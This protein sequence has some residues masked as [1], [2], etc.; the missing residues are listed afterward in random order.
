MATNTTD[1]TTD[2]LL[3]DDDG[4]ITTATCNSCCSAPPSNTTSEEEPEAVIK[5]FMFEGRSQEFVE[6]IGPRFEEHTNG[7]VKVDF[8]VVP[9]AEGDTFL[10][11]I[12]N[13]ARLGLGLYD[14]CE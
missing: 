3:T 1:N 10:S 5:V 4:N 11:E 13:G 9:W 14:V 2:I 6:L 12:E 7:R 8:S